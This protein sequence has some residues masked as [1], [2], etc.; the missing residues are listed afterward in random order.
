MPPPAPR[1]AL[2]R[3]W[4]WGA[5]LPAA[6]AAAIFLRTLRA[7]FT[8]DDRA[9]VQENLDVI[10]PARAWQRLLR[11]DFWGAPVHLTTSNKSYRCVARVQPSA[12]ERSRLAT[13]HARRA[14]ACRRRPLTTA[15][16]RLVRAASTPRG[17][18]VRAAP[19]HALNVALHAGA[20]LRNCV[21]A[22]STSGPA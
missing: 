1:A 19:F 8:F 18:A 20:H 4:W 7:G 22:A 3:R 2:R 15:M 21:Q 5:A 16:F 11:A 13:P 6:V 17:A 10:D 12:K 14:E 9:A